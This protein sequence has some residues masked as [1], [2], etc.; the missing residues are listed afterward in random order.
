MVEDHGQTLR[1]NSSLFSSFADRNVV[2]PDT[3][4]SRTCTVRRRRL[5]SIATCLVFAHCF[6]KR[7]LLLVVFKKD[8]SR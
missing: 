8:H 1:L 7:V 5:P 4:R 3:P 2:S 6:K